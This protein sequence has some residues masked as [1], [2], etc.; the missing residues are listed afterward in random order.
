ME[1]GGLAASARHGPGLITEGPDREQKTAAAGNRPRGKLPPHAWNTQWNYKLHLSLL[2]YYV[3][4]KNLVKLSW[5]YQYAAMPPHD[6]R[7]LRRG[8]ERRRGSAAQGRLVGSAYP[9]SP[10][11][12]LSRCP[13]LRAPRSLATLC[14]SRVRLD[15]IECDG[16]LVLVR[17]RHPKDCTL[18]NE[19]RLVTRLDH[20]VHTRAAAAAA[21]A[22]RGLLLRGRQ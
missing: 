6:V 2:L 18:H 17:R 8:S 13:Q 12:I 1:P 4:Y 3:K 22:A 9:C 20:H 7:E 16:A 19:Q 15:K 10:S 14:R 11:R 5:N 21:V